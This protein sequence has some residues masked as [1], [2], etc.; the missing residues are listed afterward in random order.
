M[1]D[2]ITIIRPHCQEPAKTLRLSQ[3]LE[4]GLSGQDV[5]ILEAEED[6]LSA[7]LRNRRILFAISLGESGINLEYYSLL[8][9][10]RL[11]QHLFDGSVG[12]ILIDGNSELYTKAVSRDL[13]F[14]ANRAGCSFVGKPLVEGTRT[15][16]NFNITAKNLHLDNEEAYCQSARDLVQ[17]IASHE[18]PHMDRPRLLVLHAGNPERSNTML[19]WQMIS[20]HLTADIDVISLR[21]GEIRDCRGCS[22]ETC[23]HLGEKGRCFYGGIITNEV[24]PR[25]LECNGL[26][27]LCPNYNDALGAY[28]SAFINRLTAIFRSHQF[29]DKRLYAVI[30]SGYSGSDIVARQLISSMNMNRTFLLPPRFA[31]M[32]TANNPRSIE[33]VPGIGRDAEDFSR[34]MMREFAG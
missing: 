32:R 31:M 8:K 33:S 22:Y 14:S 11:D 10:M 19:L 12:G 26:V 5:E 18:P 4:F 27:M 17:R 30:V 34:S 3:V 21:D 2:K 23:L 13:V 29:Y 25:L 9:R 15:L 1:E 28:L 16:A 7:D 20:S 6:I 24:Y